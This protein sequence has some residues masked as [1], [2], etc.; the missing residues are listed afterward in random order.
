MDLSIIIVNWNSAE[1]VKQCVCSVKEQTTGIEY[2][3]IVVDNG[4]FDACRKMLAEHFPDVVFL[5]I[6]RNVGF[7]SA[8]NCGAG[9]ARG[10]TLLFLNP[11]T[12]VL[13]HAID[14]LYERFMHIGNPGAVGCRLLNGDGTLQTSCVQSFP[15]VLNQLLN[16]DALQRMFPHS[17]L[18]G[19]TALSGKGDAPQKVAVVSGACLMSRRDVFELV[20]RFSP[21][22]FMYAEDLDL[23]YKMQQAGFHNVYI[24]E[25]EII[26]YGGG[27]T[28]TSGNN[29]GNLMMCESIYR[30]LRKTRGHTYSGLYRVSLSGAALLRM[31]I[32]GALYPVWRA[33]GM[34]RQWTATVRKWRAISRWGVG[35][36]QWTRTYDGQVPAADC[37]NGDA[38]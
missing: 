4:S 21:E 32:A 34:E 17:R 29:F 13:D 5:Q 38:I 20:G 9:R 16:A 37:L 28:G 11:D 7:G 30:F 1:Y 25:A 8:N 26:H 35:L 12:R 24:P 6:P 2:E 15:T 27:S 31:A 33:R 18:W 36:E 10:N 23:C 19:K 14:R 22:Y 3:I